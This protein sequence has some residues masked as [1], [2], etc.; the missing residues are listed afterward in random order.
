MLNLIG[1]SG[2]LISCATCFAISLHAVSLSL[3]A[4]FTALDLSLSIIVLYDS[5][6]ATTSLGVLSFSIFIFLS[7]RRVCLIVFPIASRDF[8]TKLD[9]KKAITNATKIMFPCTNPSLIKKLLLSSL[10]AV[11]S[12]KYGI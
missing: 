12:A 10:L 9:M 11:S 4:S 3:L 2:F 1:V 6:R 7:V 5:T 8:V